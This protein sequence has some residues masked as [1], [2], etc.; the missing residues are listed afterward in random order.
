MKIISFNI[1]GIR[2]HIHQLK[3][4]IKIHNPDIIGLQETRV[5]DIDFPIEQLSVL[6]YDILFYGQKKYYGVA[7]F[8]RFKII[9][10]QKGFLK[11]NDTTQK[12]III[13]DLDSSIGNIK[14]I[15]CYF[16]QGENRNNLVKFQ[17]K[18]NFFNTLYK[19]IKNYLKP[20]DHIIIMGDINVT[21]SNLD[22]GIGEKNR[23]KWLQIG[24]CSF[25]PEERFYV[26]Q[27]LNWGL[28]DIW[29]IMHPKT[30]NK[31]SWFDYRSKGYQIN[32]GL[33]IDNILISKS[34][35]RYYVDSDI[36]YFIRSMK[37]SSD[38]APIWVEFRI[39]N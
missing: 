6:G 18:I 24:K 37:C 25:L 10:I 30:N 36:D 38:H 28:F 5:C 26:H 9:N 11:N 20:T 15:N 4:I 39:F 1:N 13:M 2:A 33:R 21:I 16:P 7:F 32:Q 3:L 14:I 23:I 29:R 22:I 12:R 35:I 27:L 31:F 19:Y 34:L 8:S 17:Y